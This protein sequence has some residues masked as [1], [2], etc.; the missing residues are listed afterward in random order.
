MNLPPFAALPDLEARAD[1]P[2]DEIVG[3]ALLDD[4]SVQIRSYT[5]RSFVGADSVLLAV[6]EALDAL[7]TVCTRAAKRVLDNPKGVIQQQT[8]PFA[9]M[10]PATAADGI[11]FTKSEKETLDYAVR[12]AYPSTCTVPGLSTISMTR[13]P[14]ETRPTVPCYLEEEICELLLWGE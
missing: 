4:V 13:G 7:R 3:Q 5:G 6:P 11:F 14:L 1:G 8:G 10:R 12:L 2:V 9:D